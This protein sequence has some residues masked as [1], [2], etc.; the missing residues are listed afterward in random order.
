MKK[1]RT[2]RILP[3]LGT[4]RRERT[5]ALSLKSLGTHLEVL[6]PRLRPFVNALIPRT[7]LST[8]LVRRRTWMSGST[9]RSGMVRKL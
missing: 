9:M 6:A 7:T 2:I 3:I 5:Q 8:N 4:R 1:R